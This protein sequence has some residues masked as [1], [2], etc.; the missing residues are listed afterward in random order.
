MLTLD[1]LKAIQA[2]VSVKNTRAK[3]IHVYNSAGTILLETY[4]TVTAFQKESGLNG[5]DIT[6]IAN[7]STLL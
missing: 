4:K 7:S 3:A 6:K 5:S 2:N 1:Q